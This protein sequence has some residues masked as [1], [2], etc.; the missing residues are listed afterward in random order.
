MEAPRSWFEFLFGLSSEQQIDLAYSLAL[1][2]TVILLRWL[3]L[4]IVFAR[5]EDVRVRFRWRKV[6]AYL[7][8]I[9][10]AF[11]LMRIWL[12]GVTGLATYLGLL[13]AGVAIALRDPLVNLAAWVFLLWRKP[14]EVG[15]RIEVDSVAGDVV[16]IRIFQFTLMEIGN[17]VHADQ[18]TGRVLHL[19][20][21]VVF[22][23]PLANYTKGFQFIWNE[24]EVMVTFESDWR[25]AKQILQELGERHSQH[26]SEQAAEQVR[27]ASQRYMIFYS[28][29]TP[30]TY[31][32][33][34]ASG[35]LLT[36]RYLCDPRRRRGSAEEIWEDVLDAFA[37]RPDIDFAYPT[38]RFY[39]NRL[40]GK[41]EARA[42]LR[43]RATGEAAGVEAPRGD[44]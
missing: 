36:L 3:L 20:N 10:V 23:K 34:A 32:A 2:L 22:N 35:V 24:I 28:K 15:D 27:R 26:L 11:G 6:T 7:A 39:D 44:E 38:Q 8:T 31:T 9:V 4:R 16:D 18:S 5:S 41:R 30:R 12:G 25:A 40:E 37:A 17:W 21:G 1:L 14:F 13:S 43:P 29:L 33:V 19:P 42:P